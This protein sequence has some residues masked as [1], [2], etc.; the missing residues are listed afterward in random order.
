MY[1]I[2]HHWNMERKTLPKFENGTICY[3]QNCVGATAEIVERV[4]VNRYKC[5]ILTFRRNM[6]VGNVV[7]IAR[8]NLKIKK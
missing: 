5:K 8:S 2:N 7:E 6:Y 1:K 4:S 3:I